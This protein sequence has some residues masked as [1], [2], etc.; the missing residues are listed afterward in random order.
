M[1]LILVLPRE[2]QVDMRSKASM[3][4]EFP[5]PL[6][7][8]YLGLKEKKIKASMD[9]QRKLLLVSITEMEFH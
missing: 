1:P 3:V 8:D 5:G 2:G 7:R 9:L 4:Y 6:E